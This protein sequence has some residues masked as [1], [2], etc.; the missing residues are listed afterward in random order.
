MIMEKTGTAILFVDDEPHYAIKYREAL[1]KQFS[2]PFCDNAN[3]ALL[4][5]QNHDEL[6]L[7]VLDIMM[8]TPEGIDAIETNNGDETGLWMI[9]KCKEILSN[10]PLPILALTNRNRQPIL[11]KLTEFHLPTGLIEVR[12][13]LETPARDLPAFASNLIQR[14]FSSTQSRV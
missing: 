7:V 14:W 1:E 10:R 5:I 11:D 3:E 2:V 8:P 12:R 13:K 9:Q 6:R 4:Y